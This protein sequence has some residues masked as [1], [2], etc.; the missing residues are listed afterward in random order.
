MIVVLVDESGFYVEK[1]GMS[2]LEINVTLSIV[3]RLT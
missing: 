3:V 1:Q 2:N